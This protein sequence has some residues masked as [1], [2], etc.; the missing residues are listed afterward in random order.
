MP[1][2]TTAD[3]HA[4]DAFFWSTWQLKPIPDRL[5]EPQRPP[6]RGIDQG[7]AMFL[8]RGSQSWFDG[9]VRRLLLADSP[10]PDSTARSR[11]ARCEP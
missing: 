7:L 1:Q 3:R 4:A 10:S 5:Q 6:G 2:P 8:E 9:S 11:G